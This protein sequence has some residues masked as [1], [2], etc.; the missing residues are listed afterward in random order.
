M[1]R[2]QIIPPLISG[3]LGLIGGLF[4][5][6]GVMRSVMRRERLS[7]SERLKILLREVIVKLEDIHGHPVSVVK[8]R[9]IDN[10]AS[11]LL[12]VMRGRSRCH[13]RKAWEKYR[14]EPNDKAHTPFE[15]TNIESQG[16]RYEKAKELITERLNHLIN[17]LNKIA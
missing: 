1:T 2:E 12:A 8:N 17:L 6:W 5:T 14:Y 13:F 3:V 9:E 4:A 10:A 16:D 15:Y 11:D 7:R